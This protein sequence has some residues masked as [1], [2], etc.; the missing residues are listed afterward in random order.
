MADHE[1]AEF[2]RL[3]KN[4]FQDEALRRMARKAGVHGASRKETDDVNQALR[5][6]GYRI[7]DNFCEK[8]A[9]YTEH[10]KS[11]TVSEQDFRNTCDLLKIKLDFYATPSRENNTFPRC[12]AYSPGRVVNR[13]VRGTRADLE[14]QHENRYS[15]ADCV[16]NEQLPFARLVRD[17]MENHYRGVRFTPQTLSWLQYMAEFFLI[18]V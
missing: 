2:Q 13:R 12:K 7:L 6:L 5:A 18:K 11:K 15:A 1:A 14:T 9:V 17:I 10:R 4:A 3:L 16:Y 8:L